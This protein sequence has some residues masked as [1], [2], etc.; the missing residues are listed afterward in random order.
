MN[1]FELRDGEMFCEDVPLSQVAGAVGTPVYVYS[2]ATL[3]RHFTVL[4]TALS[5]AGLRDDAGGPPLIAYAVKANSNL[6]VLATLAR[7]GAGADTVSEGEIRR[8]LAAG[9]PPERIVFSGV[10]KQAGEIRFALETGISEINVESEPEMRLIAQVAQGLGRPAR[11]AFR[12]NPDVA[13]GGHA[14]IATGGADNKFGVSFSEAERLYAE[15]ASDPWLDPIGLTCHIGSQISRLEPMEAAFLRMRELV[16]RL[17]ARGLAVH[18]LDLGGGLGVPYFN[19]PEPPTPAAYAAMIAGVMAGLEIGLA[20]EPGRVIAANA[21][22]LLARVLHIHGRPEG[23]RFVVLDAAM[24]DLIRPAMYDAYHDIRPVR[25]RPGA[26]AI[27]DVVGPV[28]ETGD[29]FTR[30]RMLPPLEAGDLVAFMSAGAYGASMSSE[31]NSRL[32]VPEVLVRGA[33]WAVV[34]PRPT[35]E[36]MLARE[37][38]PTWLD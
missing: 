16:E 27:A 35:Y 34:R 22:I 36:E 37:S 7:L 24:N 31:Y 6:A 25:P 38:R 2:S 5:D 32:L 20:F 33:D 4:Q 17:R 15:A 11:I 28:C 26:A 13:A 29:T 14:K 8:A 1:H 19:Q 21:G 3:E 23:R 12:V 9:V 30:D 18:R 10:G